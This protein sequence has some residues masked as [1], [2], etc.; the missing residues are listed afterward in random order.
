MSGVGSDPAPKLSEPS[1]LRQGREQPY[2]PRRLLCGGTWIAVAALALTAYRIAR[3]YYRATW[4]LGCPDRQIPSDNTPPRQ[5]SRSA[6]SGAGPRTRTVTIVVVEMR[7][8]CLSV[9]VLCVCGDIM[10]EW[11]ISWSI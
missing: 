5:C 6:P 2:L 8:V 4:P 7:P 9:S 11:M 3:T 10:C 1:S